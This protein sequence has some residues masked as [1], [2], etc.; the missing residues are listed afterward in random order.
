[1]QHAFVTTR[2]QEQ[3]RNEGCFAST[4]LHDVDANMMSMWV[5][6]LRALVILWVAGCGDANDV[7]TDASSRPPDTGSPIDAIVADALDAPADAQ[8]SIDAPTS[9]DAASGDAS[10]SC[11]PVMHAPVANRICSVDDWCWEQPLPQGEILS[12]A[13]GLNSNDVWAAGKHGT[14]L[15]WNGTLWSRVGGTP[16]VDLTGI[17]ASAS[18]DVWAVGGNQVLRWNGSTWSSMTSAAGAIAVW[19]SAANDV[20]ICSSS[21]A[22]MLHW[23]GST[24]SQASTGVSGFPHHMFGTAANDIW[25]AAQDRLFHWDG[26]S[27]GTVNCPTTNYCDSVWGTAANDIWVGNS[28]WGSLYHWTGASWTTVGGTAN[29]QFISAMGGGPGSVW[30]GGYHGELDH[31]TTTSFT[32][33]M[34]GSLNSIYAMASIS[35]S[36]IWALGDQG[37][38]LHYDGTSWNK[39]SRDFEEGFGQIYGVGGSSA[40]NVWA[41]GQSNVLGGLA[42]HRTSTGWASVPSGTT[43]PFNAVWSDAPDDAWMVG[44]AG[45]RQH[46]DGSGWQRYTADLSFGQDLNGVWGSG[47]S[48]VWTVGIRGPSTNLLL[49]HWDGVTWSFAPGQSLSSFR[50]ALGDNLN[51]VWGASA[52]D[53]WI[54]GSAGGIAHWDG[55]SWSLV[56]TAPHAVAALWGTGSGNVWAV[57]DAGMILHY[58]GA[59]WTSVPSGTTVPLKAISGRGGDDVFAV[60]VFSVPHWDGCSWSPQTPVSHDL[61]TSVWTAPGAPAWVVGGISI[62]VQSSTGGL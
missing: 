38:T 49:G 6:W 15:H 25:I 48:D 37:L 40:T 61:M 58:D 57:G 56:T 17:W 62:S 59:Q 39:L 45:I 41:V 31:W 22:T 47:P 19:G 21:V 4:P 27:W 16:D 36:D 34:S 42:L 26:S 60:G 51:S 1:L 7:P 33:G 32:T 53:V 13:W 30:A 5:R 44:Y 55:Q 23:D 12:A 9:S 20:W 50:T 10:N 11:T 43:N 35:A 8:Q 14:V 3:H 28:D 24:L 52:S 46:W 18:N 29:Q 2:R 54:G